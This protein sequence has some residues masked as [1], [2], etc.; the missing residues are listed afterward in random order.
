[1]KPRRPSRE[2]GQRPSPAQ[3]PAAIAN[4]GGK[5]QGWAIVENQTDSDWENVQLSLV[6]GRPISFI[7]DLYQPL[8]VTRPTVE[9]EL[10]ASLRPQNYAGAM[11]Y[12]LEQAAQLAETD[13]KS[14]QD[15]G[16]GMARAAAAPPSSLRSMHG[17]AGG[18]LAGANAMSDSLKRAA[19]DPTASVAAAAS[20]ASVGEFFQYTV[21]D[22]SLPRQKSAMIP[23]I[24]DVVRAS[25]LS[26]FNAGVLVDHPLLGLG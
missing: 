16:R 21:G 18:D 7:E 26:I 13:E 19:M 10:Y 1:M 11:D 4:D 17:Y 20:G 22:V 12:R 25:R 8:F 9:P 23:I 24:T 6:S 2:A 15:R 14:K 3:E 5:L